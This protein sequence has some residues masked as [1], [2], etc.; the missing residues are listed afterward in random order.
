MLYEYNNKIYI[1]PFSNKLVEVEVIKKDKDYVVKPTT[2]KVLIT[3][4]IKETMV[5]ITLENAFKKLHSS[6]DI[7]ASIDTL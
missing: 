6:R 4:E 1:R 7:K 3:N 2:K 5:E